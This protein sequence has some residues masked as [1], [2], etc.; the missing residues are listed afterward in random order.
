MGTAVWHPKWWTKDQH[1]NAWECVKE[2]LRRDW[3]QT[4]VDLQGYGQDLNQGIDDTVK[5]AAGDEPIPPGNQPN[6]K[7]PP[8]PVT[9]PVWQDV[10]EPM[11]YGYGAREYYGAQYKT[12][13]DKLESTLKEE[14]ESD[15]GGSHRSWADVKAWVKRGYER[16]V[17]H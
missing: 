15:E 7:P 11:K 6:V 8:R 17:H 1:E 5:Q 4:K 12:W 3:E 13:D 16:A 10:E 14:W 2:A 9:K